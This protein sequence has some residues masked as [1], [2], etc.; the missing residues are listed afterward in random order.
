VS[1]QL[2]AFQKKQRQ[3]VI[4]AM[5]AA[6]NQIE[7]E[8]EKF[9]YYP[10]PDHEL[11]VKEL[12]RRAKIGYSTLKNKTHAGTRQAA[13]SWLQRMKLKLNATQ[14]SKSI[15]PN[16]AEAA[17]L[18]LTALARNLDLFKLQFEA[19]TE[20]RDA[21]LDERDTLKADN[22][23]LR[24]EIVRLKAGSTKVVEFPDPKTRK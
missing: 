9:G 5:K 24:A 18:S 23:S 15:D 1:E 17:A 4:D 21:L 22:K 16:K 12:C 13:K 6:Q 11:N 14:R 19:I 3:A 2:V 7:Q 10:E 8:I 20:E